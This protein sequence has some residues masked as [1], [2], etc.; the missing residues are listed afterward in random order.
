MAVKNLPSFPEQ[1]RLAQIFL[2]Q[3]EINKINILLVTSE[4]RKK[5]VVSLRQWNWSIYSDT[6]YRQRKSSGMIFVPIP[7]LKSLEQRISFGNH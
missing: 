2:C 3:K 4:L 6:N 1:L 7:D 5:N